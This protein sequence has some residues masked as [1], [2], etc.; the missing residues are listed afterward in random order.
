MRLM[1]ICGV[2]CALNMDTR[3]VYVYT[4]TYILIYHMLGYIDMCIYVHMDSRRSTYAKYKYTIIRIHI[5][6]YMNMQIYIDRQL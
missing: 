4:Y 2:I 3:R 6:V 5:C 1:C